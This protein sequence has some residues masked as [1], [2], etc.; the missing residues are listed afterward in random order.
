MI[1]ALGFFYQERIWDWWV[2]KKLAKDPRPAIAKFESLD[3]KAK[4]RVPE[5][6]SYYDA[7][8]GQSLKARDTVATEQGNK[9]VLSFKS[10]LRVEVQPDSML[11]INDEPLKSSDLEFTFLRGQVK[12]L[13]DE[14]SAMATQM[15]LEEP[16]VVAVNKSKGEDKTPKDE[17]RKKQPLPETYISSMVRDQK[18]LLYRCY[19][20]HLINNPKSTGRIDTSFMIE[21]DGNVSSSRVIGST[22]ADGALQQCVITVISR[23]H[24]KGFHGDTMIVT[25]PVKFE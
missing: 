20:L 19:A 13:N 12:I 18:N 5:S 23:I 17:T 11:I 2:L 22:I 8:S 16:P 7:H 6:V 1:A 15:N 25:Y 10:G 9:T 24:F 14:K 21:P 3:K 4:F